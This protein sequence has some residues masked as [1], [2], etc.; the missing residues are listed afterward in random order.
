MGFNNFIRRIREGA[1][2]TEQPIIDPITPE[3]HHRMDQEAS[4]QQAIRQAKLTQVRNREPDYGFL[5]PDNPNIVQPITFYDSREEEAVRQKVNARI[6]ENEATHRDVL[7]EIGQ[8]SGK[9]SM[10]VMIEPHYECLC[11]IGLEIGNDRLIVPFYGVKGFSAVESFIQFGEGKKTQ[12]IIHIKHNLDMGT[13]TIDPYTHPQNISLVMPSPFAQNHPLIAKLRETY[14]FQIDPMPMG[15]PD[16]GIIPY[17]PPDGSFWSHFNNGISGKY[18]AGGAA[19]PDTIAFMNGVN[20]GQLAILLTA[21]QKHIKHPGKARDFINNH[22]RSLIPAHVLQQ[23]GQAA[24]SHAIYKRVVASGG[25]LPV[26]VVEGEQPPMGGG[27]HP[28]TQI[29]YNGTYGASVEDYTL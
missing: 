17:A 21:Y 25:K 23:R 19:Q 4:I 28:A 20:S 18:S 3:A 22:Y 12:A 5:T 9:P 7:R 6:A 15:D 10:T 8:R 13:F 2:Y 14:P 26:G 27:I 24:S 11:R 1:D 16:R 29:L